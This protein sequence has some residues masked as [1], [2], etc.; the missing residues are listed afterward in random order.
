M[1]YLTEVRERRFQWDGTF[2]TFDTLRQETRVARPTLVIKH[3]GGRLLSWRLEDMPPLHG[4]RE[5][6]PA[7][8]GSVGSPFNTRFLDATSEIIDILSD[9]QIVTAQVLAG[10]L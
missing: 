8:E 6:N 2:E 9:A 3:R 4:S 7:P 10:Q 1:P 5:D